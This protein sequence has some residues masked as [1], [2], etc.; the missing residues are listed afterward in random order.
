MRRTVLLLVPALALLAA[1]GAAALLTGDGHRSGATPTVVTTS[2]P[3]TASSRAPLASSAPAPL[4]ALAVIGDY[5]IEGGA[6]PTMVRTLSRW[7]SAHAPSGRFAALLTTGDNAY[8]SGTAAQAR[9]ARSLVAPLVRPGTSLLASLGNH[10]VGTDGGRPVMAAFGMPAKWYAR[11]VG[12]T[13]VIVLDSNQP[14]SS[15]QVAWLRRTLDAPRTTRFRVAVFHHPAAAC[16]T[17]EADP[18]VD[19]Y[20][21]PLLNRTGGRGVDLVLSGHDHTYER[22]RTSAGLPL[23]TT[24]GGGAR[25]YPSSSV[26]CTG[27]AAK[28]SLHTRFNVVVMQVSQ[29]RILLTS[30][31]RDGKALDRAYVLPR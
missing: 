7:A 19:R 31:D 5:G 13:Q 16:S 18:Q 22:F 25:L 20:W 6:A 2:A 12:S 14:A 21:L 24:G 29:W 4:P 23:V 9:Y 28:Q 10:D 11:T 1:G 3:P 8:S 26:A 30:L 17:H 15:A 27:P